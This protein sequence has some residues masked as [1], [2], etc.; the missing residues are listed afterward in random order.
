MRACVYVCIGD[1]PWR[2][3][4][5]TDQCFC[6]L[7]SW[8]ILPFPLDRAFLY[9]P[10]STSL[11]CYHDNIILPPQSPLYYAVPILMLFH[12]QPT[13]L[14]TVSPVADCIGA[15]PKSLKINCLIQLYWR[16]IV[17][18]AG[19]VSMVTLVR[20]CF[21]IFH[22]LILPSFVAHTH[23]YAVTLLASAWDAQL[24]T[25]EYSSIFKN[26]NGIEWGVW[27]FFFPTV[28]MSLFMASLFYQC[29]SEWK[30]I[31]TEAVRGD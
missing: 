29:S 2:G 3:Y 16:K 31:C 15:W 30:N 4:I 26:V 5:I 10:T 13:L 7:A 12:R 17:A 28:K 22:T 20:V 6:C 11:A 21:C 27:F 18:L 1:L 14:Y 23:I 19:A 25:D 24:Q 8:L 9:C